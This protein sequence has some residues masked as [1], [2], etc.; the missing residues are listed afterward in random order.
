MSDN[1]ALAL[2]DLDHFKRINDTYGHDAGDNVLKTVG[3][4]LEEAFSEQIVARFGGEEFCVYFPYH[5]G[6]Y[7]KEQL[8]AFRIALENQVISVTDTTINITCSIGIADHATQ[9]IEDLLSAA[10]KQLYCAKNNGRNQISY[11]SVTLAG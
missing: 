2:I 5:D 1:H 9:S 4:L 6:H 11:N 7:A 3:Q 8:D 10:D